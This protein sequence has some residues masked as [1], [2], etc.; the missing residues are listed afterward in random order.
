[1]IPCPYSK[2]VLDRQLVRDGVL[3]TEGSG[4]SERPLLVD[5]WGSKLTCTVLDGG[6]T[7]QQHGAF[8]AAVIHWTKWVEGQAAQELQNLFLV[9]LPQQVI[10]E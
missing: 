9:S 6:W 2:G 8:Q 4:G 3:L 10:T 5:K 1:M 7:T